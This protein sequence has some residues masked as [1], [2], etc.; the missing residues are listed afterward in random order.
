[1][2]A[3]AAR[4]GVIVVDSNLM[5][6]ASNPDAVQILTFPKSPNGIPDVDKY[7]VTRVRERLLDHRSENQSGFV[8]DFKSARRRYLCHALPINVY[9]DLYTPR[10]APLVVLLQR[11]S[12]GSRTMDEIAKRFGFTGREQ[13]TVKLLSQGLTNKEIAHYMNISPNTV[14]A[15]I[16]LVMVKMDVSTRSGIMGR[17]V[18]SQRVVDSQR[19]ENHLASYAGSGGFALLT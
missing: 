18:N 19:R 16:R 10:G 1:M 2:Y 12:N 4:M 5:L 15:F 7:L 14:K 9:V 8:P 17:I 6:L 13:E 3:V 11:T